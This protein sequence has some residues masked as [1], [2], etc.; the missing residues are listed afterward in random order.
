MDNANRIE[1]QAQ[2]ARPAF[3]TSVTLTGRTSSAIRADT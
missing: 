2:H 3:L 1:H